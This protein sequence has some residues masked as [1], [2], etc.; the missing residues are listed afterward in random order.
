MTLS[1]Y[2]VS[3]HAGKPYTSIIHVMWAT[4]EIPSRWK[5]SASSWPD[6]HPDF[7]YC[8]WNDTELEAFVADEYPW[9][10]STYLAYPYVIQRCDVARYLLLYHYGGTYVDLDVLCRIPMPVI[11]A[12][13]PV[14]AGVIVAATTPIGISQ[15][16]IA[17]RRPRD[18]VMRGI[19]AGLRRAAA[20]RWYPPLPYTA[21][22]YRTGPVYF[23]R[24]INCY[25]AEG[26]AFI[27]S[28]SQYDRYVDHV[29]G[30]S[31]H[32]WD[33]RIIWKL[34]QRVERLYDHTVLIA[35]LSVALVLFIVIIRYRCCFRRLPKS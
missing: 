33:G 14:N 25:G 27:I 32:S 35:V 3:A 31:W 29:G 34:Y 17:V 12:R 19:I 2:N 15:E 28:A 30:A 23:T 8:V 24:L 6:K 18:P 4:S 11:F 9:L 26:R 10:L 20:S 16:F 7:V 21:V 5:R 1:R 22:M 13:T